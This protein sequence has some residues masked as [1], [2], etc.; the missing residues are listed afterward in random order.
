M[1]LF[2]A[3]Y[4]QAGAQIPE[5]KAAEQGNP[6]AQLDVGIAYFEGVGVDTDTIEAIKWFRRAA[7]QGLAEAQY[8]IGWAYK[9]GIGGMPKDAAEA[10]SW[11]Q[12]AA[13]QGLA[14]AEGA[15]GNAY[16]FGVGVPQ[17]RAD[18]V[19]WLARAAKQG[20]A[21]AQVGLGMIY[22]EGNQDVKRDEAEA[23]RLFQNAAQQGNV[24]AQAFLAVAF[25][26]GKGVPKDYKKAYFFAILAASD[27]HPNK[28]KLRNQIAGLLDT[29]TRKSVE[30]E[31]SEWK[32]KLNRRSRLRSY[33]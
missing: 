15:L 10:F 26:Q 9:T 32:P 22:S 27:Q 1:A 18:G 33:S 31:A 8:L 16:Y 2:F 5:I 17:D 30:K 20:I 25:L 28:T 4:Q 24:N 6:N 12:K 7:D 11:F 19:R 29:A 23:V 14:E 13:N 3:L 21:E